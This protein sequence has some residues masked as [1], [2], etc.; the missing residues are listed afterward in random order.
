MH[1]PRLLR[2]FA[3]FHYFISTS[4]CD[5]DA[6]LSRIASCFI[7]NTAS[8]PDSPLSHIQPSNALSHISQPWGHE[9]RPR[10]Y[11]FW[12][13]LWPLSALTYLQT[14][15]DQDRHRRNSGRHRYTRKFKFDHIWY[16]R[17]TTLKFPDCFTQFFSHINLATSQQ[18]LS[19]VA[20]RNYY[21]SIYFPL[22]YLCLLA[23]NQKCRST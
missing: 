14:P 4:N 5:I 21:T 6:T 9:F 15:T 11:W 20:G 12:H 2:I 13:S 3:I 1:S 23:S 17:Y 7:V 18:S 16:H 22:F 10:P 8:N 19:C